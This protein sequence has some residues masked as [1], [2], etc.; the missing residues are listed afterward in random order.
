MQRHVVA[1]VRIGVH[2][3]AHSRRRWAVNHTCDVL[4][5]GAAGA[6]HISSSAA[7]AGGPATPWEHIQALQARYSR[8]HR[9]AVNRRQYGARRP[10]VV[11]QP[12]DEPEELGHP[13][14]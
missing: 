7:R 10:L 9:E 1:P 8:R 6:W 3:A 5:I 2:F 11:R 12:R 4:A 14:N 13:D